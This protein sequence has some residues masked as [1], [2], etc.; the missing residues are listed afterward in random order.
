MLNSI[1]FA[2]SGQAMAKVKASG[3]TISRDRITTGVTRVTGADMDNN[4]RD[5]K[6]GTDRVDMEII[7]AAVAAEV[8][9]VTI[10]RFQNKC[11]RVSRGESLAPSK[12][13]VFIQP[14]GLSGKLKGSAVINRVPQSHVHNKNLELAFYYQ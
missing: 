3:E 14:T 11:V 12:L 5:R 8:L 2:C 4:S 1:Y 6:T 9:V 13:L 7:I 10:P